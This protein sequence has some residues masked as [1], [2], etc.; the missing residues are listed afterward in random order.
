MSEIFVIV[1]ARHGSPI[2]WGVNGGGFEGFTVFCG[3][4]CF[5]FTKAEAEKAL[6]AF[7]YPPNWTIKAFHA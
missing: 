5:F 7:S 4:P 6:H 1:D 3:M 2:R